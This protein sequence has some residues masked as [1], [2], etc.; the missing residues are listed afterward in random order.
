MEENDLELNEKE[1]ENAEYI[2]NV[3]KKSTSYYVH[4]DKIY[5]I[6]SN[7]VHEVY[8]LCINKSHFPISKK[9][10]DDLKDKGVEFI[11]REE[12]ED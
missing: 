11:E 3:I 7:K 9:E 6:M 8:Y 10:Y 4:K 5:D 2:L 1:K 12:T